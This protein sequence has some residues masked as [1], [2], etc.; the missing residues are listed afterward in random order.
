MKKIISLFYLLFFGTF[1]TNAQNTNNLIFKDGNQTIKIEFETK[2]PYLEL[3]KNTK[4][5]VS[6]E[7]IE[8]RKTSIICRGIRI[9]GSN[10]KTN[11]ECSV[12]VDENGIENGN[13]KMRLI[14]YDKDERKTHVFTIPVK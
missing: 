13:F 11:F 12:L 4:F 10:N 1:I 5:I 3:N 14:Y 8:L 6:V 2:Q 7:N 9:L